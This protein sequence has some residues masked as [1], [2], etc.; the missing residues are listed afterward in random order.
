MLEQALL[1]NHFIMLIFN[2]LKFALEVSSFIPLQD[3]VD[4][5]PSK[6]KDSKQPQKMT[7]SLSKLLV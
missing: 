3:I 4:V 6:L 2:Y 5:E 1:L 7:L